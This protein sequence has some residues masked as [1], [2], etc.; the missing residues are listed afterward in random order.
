[1][2]IRYYKPL[3]LNSFS[4][5]SSWSLTLKH[6]S[7]VILFAHISKLSE[8]QCDEDSNQIKCD[9]SDNM[10]E[11]GQFDVRFIKWC[12]VSTVPL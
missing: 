9:P 8:M 7:E 4:S 10:P 12:T 2:L 11:N 5:L 6:W 3:C 1:M